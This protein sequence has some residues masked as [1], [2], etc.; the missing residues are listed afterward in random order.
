MCGLVACLGIAMT[1]LTAMGAKA[2]DERVRV[3]FRNRIPGV[4]DAPVY[5][6]DGLSGL[7]TGRYMAVLNVGPETNSF[8]PSGPGREFLSGTN[9]GYW[10]YETPLET[11]VWFQASLGQKIWYKVKIGEWLPEFPF[12]KVVWV[13]ESASYSMVVTNYVMPMLGLESFKLVPERLEIS[14]QTDQ[15]VIQWQYLAAE[16]YELQGTGSLEPPVSWAPI[17]E[18]SHESTGWLDENYVFVVTNAVSDAVRFCRLKHWPV[19]WWQ[20]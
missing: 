5:G 10:A 4:V 13:G 8:A 15:V 9:A 16:R 7:A 12:G 2:A 19:S 20:P 18:W 11:V 17:Y 6:F 3:D 14:R 1:L